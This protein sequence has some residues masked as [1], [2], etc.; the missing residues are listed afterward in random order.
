M[1]DARGKSV[2]TCFYG[3]YLSYLFNAMV[4]TNRSFFLKIQLLLLIKT[5]VRNNYY[6][7]KLGLNVYDGNM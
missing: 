2:V 1:Q 5:D 6:S 7:I 4:N 3:W